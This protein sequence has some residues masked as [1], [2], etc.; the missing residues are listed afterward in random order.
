[1]DRPGLLPLHSA[2]LNSSPG[3]LPSPSPLGEPRPPLTRQSP[4][5]AKKLQAPLRFWKKTLESEGVKRG[6]GGPRVPRI[7]RA[8]RMPC[9][10]ILLFLLSPDSRRLGNEGS[11]TI[12]P[13]LERTRGRVG[14]IYPR[15]QKGTWGRALTQYNKDGLGGIEA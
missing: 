6:N 14:N 9:A 1:M 4:L 15:A 12:V 13:A 7:P 5:L 11:S 10:G 8:P 2:P 3:F